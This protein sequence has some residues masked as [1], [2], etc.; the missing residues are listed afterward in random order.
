M[1]FLC[2]VIFC[3]FWQP[4]GHH[5]ISKHIFTDQH[6]GSKDFRRHLGKLKATEVTLLS[7]D[8]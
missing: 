2:I 4:F 6:A 7:K 1:P 8:E 5:K 3:C